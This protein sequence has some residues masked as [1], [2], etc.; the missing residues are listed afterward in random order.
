M[1]Q[2]DAHHRRRRQLTRA[3][4]G[5]GQRRRSALIPQADAMRCDPPLG[6]DSSRLDGEQGGT[7]VEQVAPVH[8][9]PVAHHAFLRR[10]LAHG[11]HHDAIG[12]RQ[13]TAWRG[14]VQGRK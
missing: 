10:I 7:A 6:Q 1:G 8:Q 9:M 4:Q 3:L 2:L 11:R 14:Q 12:Q 5:I 13:P